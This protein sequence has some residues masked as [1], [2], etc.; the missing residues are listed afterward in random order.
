MTTNFSD[1]EQLHINQLYQI[2]LV[3]S[4]IQLSICI[5][6][7]VG[8][9][10]M[11]I[12]WIKDRCY[13]PIAVFYIFLGSSDTIF[14]IAFVIYVI[15]DIMYEKW[16]GNDESLSVKLASGTLEVFGCL[17]TYITLLI[18]ITRFYVV[19]KPFEKSFYITINYAVIS[20]AFC[21]TWS[22]ASLLLCEYTGKNDDIKEITFETLRY[23]LPV[24]LM[25]LTTIS[26]IILLVKVNRC[27]TLFCQLYVTRN[28]Q[29]TQTAPACMSL[30]V[31]V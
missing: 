19:L 29:R 16:L 5:I 17:T 21:F 3:S 7:I 11:V 23:H 9:I 13:N 27:G 15:L 8:N 26:L 4:Y 24:G 12:G 31:K 6:G 1:H 25:A 30:F 14:C 28:I 10:L 22:I 2:H 18:S 20:C